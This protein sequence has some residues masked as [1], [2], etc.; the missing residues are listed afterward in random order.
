[1]RYRRL[2]D[3]FE[4]ESSHYSTAESDK[5]GIIYAQRL[6]NSDAE[7][8]MNAIRRTGL[9]AEDA[10][11]Q[12]QTLCQRDAAVAFMLSVAGVIALTCTRLAEQAYTSMYDRQRSALTARL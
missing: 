6:E 10:E 1:M 11:Y 8:K 2:C 7:R 9:R 4:D 3:G 12:T 5:S